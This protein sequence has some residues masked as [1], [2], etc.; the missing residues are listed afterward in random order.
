MKDSES[1]FWEYV[2]KASASIKAFT[3]AHFFGR[4]IRPDAFAS[5]IDWNVFLQEVATNVQQQQTC[6]KNIRQNAITSAGFS[7]RIQDLGSVC[8]LLWLNYYICIG[9]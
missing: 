6:D 5:P 8:T 9:M 7:R 1:V 3:L 4:H 2:L